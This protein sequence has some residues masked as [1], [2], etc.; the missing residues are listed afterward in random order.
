MRWL[1]TGLVA[2][3][4][5]GA[6]SA[7]DDTP[8]NSTVDSAGV[9]H[10]EI[11]DAIP[12]LGIDSTS[13]QANVV[14]NTRIDESPVNE[15]V[16]QTVS[17]TDSRHMELGAYRSALEKFEEHGPYYY[18]SA[19]V[20][21]GLAHELQKQGNHHEALKYFQQSMHINRIN[22]GL[23]GLSQAPMLRGIID[24]QKVLHQFEEVTLDYRRLLDLLLKNSTEASPELISALRE[25]AIWHAD[26][27]QLDTGQTRVD[28]L[29][30]ANSMI[31][32]AINS[33]NGRDDIDTAAQID[34]LQTAALVSLRSSWHEGDEWSSVNDSQYSASA[35]KN[36]MNPTRMATLSKKSFRSGRLAH[37]QIIALGEAANVST[38][39]K[40]TAYVD[41]GDWYLMFNHLGK[42][43]E[44]YQKAQQ[45][46]TVGPQPESMGR[47]FDEP[48][49]LP[50]LNS[51]RELRNSASIYV[52]AQLD[53]SEN[54]RTSKIVIIE[55][56]PEGN[57]A[58]RR[59]ATKAIKKSRFRPRF[60]NG[61][62]VSSVA[63]IVS[64]PLIR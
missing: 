2:I 30:S 3:F 24:S 9:P 61:K 14:D 50:V 28:H 27:Y 40:I 58:V 12:A 29:T 17:S 36:F 62:A 37:E 10:Q 46:I 38:D 56:L 16:N 43:M 52:K 25:L 20:L 31:N 8:I 34:L 13:Q 15:N 39:Q 26:I 33:S 51:D 7:P 63:A 6:Q 60:V 19:E 48:R 57:G 45:L 55:P 1:I 59:A 32:M 4:V 18:Q 54:G 47:W 53:I 64:L 44:Y 11:T 23:S 42:A 49:F 22:D 21:Y 41:M 35:D 5:P